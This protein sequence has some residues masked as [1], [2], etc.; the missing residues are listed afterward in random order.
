MEDIC[1]FYSRGMT[2]VKDV[3]LWHDKELKP[4][5]KSLGNVR[6]LYLDIKNV[7]QKEIKIGI[8]RNTPK[9]PSVKR[10]LFHC[11]QIDCKI[12]LLLRDTLSQK[13][14][15]AKK[16]ISFNH[17]VEIKIICSVIL[18]HTGVIKTNNSLWNF[19]QYLD[20]SL[21]LALQ[22]KVLHS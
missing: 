16:N 11:R 2:V 4:S 10:W 22:K 21:F 19:Y 1:C 15:H 8:G 18:Q 3:S 12:G 9:I 20:H 6:A 5:S 7:C 17:V 14:L 13:V